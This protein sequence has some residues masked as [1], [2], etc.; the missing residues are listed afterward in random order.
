MAT[1]QKQDK[2]VSTINLDDPDDNTILE[3]VTSRE[4]NQEDNE[5]PEDTDD[6]VFDFSNLNLDVI[7]ND[8]EDIEKPVKKTKNSFKNDGTRGQELDENTSK[9]DTK[10]KKKNSAQERITQLVRENKTI[11]AQKLQSDNIAAQ[12]IK[13]LQ[14]S[15][16][17]KQSQSSKVADADAALWTSEVQK[18]K[19]KYAA[20]LD[21][22]DTTAVADAQAE[23]NDAQF[24]LNVASAR[25]GQTKVPDAKEVEEQIKQIVGHAIQAN[26]IVEQKEVVEN[27]LAVKWL[28]KNRTILRMQGV[29]KEAQDI[30]ND[31]QDEGLDIQS[32]EAF[33][34]M[35]DRLQVMFP[36]LKDWYSKP[37]RKTEVEDLEDDEDDSEEE[38]VI[39]PLKKKTPPTAGQ[40]RT[41]NNQMSDK[42]YKVK[43]GKLIVKASQFDIQMAS[44]LGLPIE[45]FMKQKIKR[46]IS[47]NKGSRSNSIFD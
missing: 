32:P 9:T 11:A 1:N 8:D 28:Q 3:N 40:S 41:E 18:A 6:N 39:K 7:V 43:D 15:E 37:N 22:G 33:A 23:L 10:T 45:Q 30:F 17:E 36:S 13:H 20:A 4:L 29:A 25:K 16:T 44:N 47:T 46:E 26:P 14:A 42:P 27:P 24:K 38:E 12:L 31:L 35:E 5:P 34:E 21:V 2:I 19:A